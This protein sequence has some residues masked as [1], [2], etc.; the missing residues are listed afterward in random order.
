VAAVASAGAAD[1]EM[2]SDAFDALNN[3]YVRDEDKMAKLQKQILGNPN[4]GDADRK[5]LLA[6]I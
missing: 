2:L 6:Q 3:M 4:T 5:A 1:E